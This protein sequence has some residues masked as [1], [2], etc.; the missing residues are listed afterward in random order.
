MPRRAMRCT[1]RW[2][3]PPAGGPGRGRTGEP[4][5]AQR[6]AGPAH[7]SAAA[8][9]RPAPARADR[10]D[11]R[12]C[13][14]PCCSWCATDFPRPRCSATPCRCCRHVVPALLRGSRSRPDRRGGT[15]PRRAR[16]RHRRG[17]GRRSGRRADRRAP[18]PFCADSLGVYL[19]WQPQRGRTDAERNCISNIRPDGLASDGGRDKLLWLIDAMRRLRLT[20]VGAEGRAARRTPI[21][22]RAG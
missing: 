19:T 13:R 20:G 1:P 11:S 17:D 7:L 2:M 6:G 3:S 8:R 16:R 4:R 18:R 14:A 22:H 5:G 9:P 12:R 21:L 15:G 10:A